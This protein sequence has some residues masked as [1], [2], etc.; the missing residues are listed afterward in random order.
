MVQDYIGALNVLLALPFL[1]LG[2]VN[3]VAL[4]WLPL[5][6]AALTLVLAWRVA[7]RLGGPVAASVTV[8][9]L[10]VN[11]SFIFWSRQGI[12][13]TNLTALIFMACLLTGL[14]WWAERRPRDLWLTAFLCGLGIYAKLL[15]IWAGAA[16]ALLALAGWL[17]GKKGAQGQPLTPQRGLAQARLRRR[18]SVAHKNPIVLWPVAVTCFLLPLWPLI[19]FNLRTAGTLASVFGNLGRSYYGVDNTAYC[20]NLLIRLEQVDTLLRGDHLWYLGGVFA[21]PWAPWIALAL[22]GSGLLVGL[23]TRPLPRAVI[24]PFLLALLVAQSA[25]TVSDLFITHYALLLPLIPLVGGLGSAGLLARG[26]RPMAQPQGGSMALPGLQLLLAAP[27]LVVVLGWA[28][29]DLWTTV[30][31]HRALT[32]SGGHATHSSAIYDLASYLERGGLT[33]PLALDWGLAASVHFLTAGQ[34]SPIE[35]FGYA[36]L[37]AADAGFTERIGPFL[38]NPDNVYLAHVAEQTI[39]R[40]RVEALA[41]LAQAEGLGLQE[42]A[43]FAERSGR[44]LFVVYRVRGLYG[45]T[46]NPD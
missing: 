46:S 22:L 36:G 25:F 10:A 40:G 7:L 43:R 45:R 14:R 3:V 32:T 13:V 15:F 39:F 41:A 2:G 26:I 8:L 44:P 27:I 12:F 34:V 4:R 5:F 9:L 29:G 20:S 1:T 28:A 11:P 24:P 23:R 17:I 19:I 42:E 6:I 21:N 35:V 31:Y 30:R 18:L 16:L 37:D 38:T 33:A